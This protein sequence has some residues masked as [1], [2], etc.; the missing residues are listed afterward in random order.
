MQKGLINKDIYDALSLAVSPQKISEF[1]AEHSNEVAFVELKTEKKSRDEISD[2]SDIFLRNRKGEMIPLSSVIKTEEKKSRSTLF[3]DKQ[4]STQYLTA[5]MENRSIVYAIKDIIFDIFDSE[6][7]GLEVKNFSLYSIDVVSNNSDIVTIEW[8]GE[9]EMTLDN[10]RDLSIA[11]IIAFILVYAILVGQFSSFMIPLLIMA[12]VP[13]AMLGILPGFAILDALYSIPLTAT[14][15]IGF[16]ALLGI[17]V[18]NA[19]IYLEYLDVLRAKGED[20]VDALVEAGEK[21]LAPIFLTSLTT[22]LGSLTIAG[23]PVWSGLAWS[24]VFGLSLSTL[25][26]LGIFPILYL[27]NQQK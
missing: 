13:L 10:F 15:L 20:L 16:I 12:T 6:N 24:I 26:T 7:S 27:R 21:R 14:A 9:F 25:L 19:I 8:G 3:R 22:V 2:F 23:D 18:N 4:V 11:M 1:H 17:V 5:E